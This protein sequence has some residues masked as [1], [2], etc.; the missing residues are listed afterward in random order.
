LAVS[1]PNL[2]TRSATVSGD[3]LTAAIT[4]ASG[5]LTNSDTYLYNA[6]GMLTSL[7]HHLGNSSATTTFA[8]NEGAGRYPLTGAAQWDKLTSIQYADGS[9]EAYTYNPATGWMTA[10]ITPFKNTALPT[11]SLAD[12]VNGHSGVNAETYTF[13]SILGGEGFRKPSYGSSYWRSKCTSGSRAVASGTVLGPDGNW[14]ADLP[15][16]GVDVYTGGH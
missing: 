4:Y 2:I 16:A 12:Y 6:S 3:D 15:M 9:W 1:P 11:G 10:C 13:S 7:T 5:T 14:R 8:Y